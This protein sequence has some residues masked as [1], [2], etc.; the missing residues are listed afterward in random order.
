MENKKKKR[1]LDKIN[2][3]FINSD[4]EERIEHVQE[5]VDG[6]KME[7]E[8]YNTDEVPPVL[9]SQL[10]AYVNLHRRILKIKEKFN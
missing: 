9:T 1:I 5:I 8:R 10:N 7:I 3:Y 4:L 6:I 2:T